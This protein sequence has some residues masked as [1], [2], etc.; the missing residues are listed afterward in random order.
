MHERLFHRS[1]THQEL[2]DSLASCVRDL[3]RAYPQMVQEDIA[4]DKG[5]LGAILHAIKIEL[6]NTI[7]S[8]KIHDILKRDYEQAVRTVELLNP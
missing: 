6:D 2:R 8:G 3:K 7:T 4:Y 5:Y 1:T